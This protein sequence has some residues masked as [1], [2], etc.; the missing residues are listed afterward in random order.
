MARIAPFRGIRYNPHKVGALSKVV[1]QPYDR[2]DSDLQTKYYDL[3]SYN[4]VRLI[5]GEQFQDDTPDDNVY[6][7][8]HDYY[9]TWFD[10]GYLLRDPT[11]ALYVYRQTFTLPDGNKLT[12]QAFI[13]ALELVEFSEGIVLPHERTLSG[14]KVDRLN[15]LRATAFNFEL[16]F[17]LY[18]DPENR[19]NALFDAAIGGRVADA[20]LQELFEKDVHQQMWA[21]SDPEVRRTVVAEM[22]PKTGLII[23]DGH[24][25]YETALNYRAEMRQKHP[26]APAHAAFNYAMVSLVSMDDPG[27]TILPTH[28]QIHDYATK[29]PGEIL[30]GAAAYFDV[31]PLADREALEAALAGATPD[32]RRIGFYDGT[33]HL[34]RLKSLD[35]MNQ[36][37]PDR[38]PE[39]RQLDVSILHELLI[40]RIMGITKKQVEA[41][42]H[43]EYFR[44]LGQALA[45]VD[46]G[47]ALCV[48]ILNPTRIAEVKA[49]SERG[50]KM[51]QKSTDFYPK[52]ISGLTL[53][54]VGQNERLQ[55]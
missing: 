43:L 8:A 52:M 40:E 42:E 2:I 27:L 41:K 44:D 15:L 19:I 37:V 6:T 18:P 53:M 48:F 11:P 25:R 35:V 30:Q 34:L 21:V 51:P 39:W 20:D 22:A 31:I 5:R 55:G 45:G 10:A 1:S 32:D 28:R 4:I 46:A 16:I 24:H 12:R 54:D 50:E 26:A 13:A 23:A 38:A 36:V 7:R 47:Q 14:P 29:T 9:H 17:M 33:Y 3:H 49:C